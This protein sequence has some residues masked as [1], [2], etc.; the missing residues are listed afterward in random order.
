MDE[1]WLAIAFIFFTFMVMIPAVADQFMK[2]K[3][4]RACVSGGNM[5]YVNGNCR[6]IQ[7]D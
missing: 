4:I 1:K 2:P 3:E 5:E 7:S 6:P